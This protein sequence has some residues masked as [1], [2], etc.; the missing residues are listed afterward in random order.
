MVSALQKAIASLYVRNGYID[1]PTPR[2]DD[3]E[4]DMSLPEISTLMCNLTY[5]GYA[6]SSNALDRLKSLSVA[7]A[8]FWSDVIN[9]TL[10]NLTGA[11]R[12]MDKHVV[13]KNFPTEVLGMSEAEYWTKQILMY[14]G[15]PNNLFTEAPVERQVLSDKN[16]QY[17]V[18]QLSSDTTLRMIFFGLLNVPSRW[19][20]TQLSDV[21]LLAIKF[22]K[23]GT[24]ALEKVKFKENLVAIACFYIH[25]NIQ[26]RAS[27]LTDV[28]RLAAALSGSD[29]SL[30]TKVL[31]KK[32]DR[33]KRKFL[34]S[35]I[36][37]CLVKSG[38]AL[39]DIAKRKVLWKKL[40]KSI[41]PG[42]YAKSFPKTVEAYDCL[43]HNRF[44]NL[45]MAKIEHGLK[46]GDRA[47]LDV[48]KQR[49]GECVRRLRSAIGVFGQEAVDVFSQILSKLQMIQL[50][51]L[52]GHFK[53]L[54]SRNYRLFPPKGKWS[55]LQVVETSEDYNIPEES[56]RRVMRLISEEVRSR[57]MQ[58]IPVV[59]IDPRVAKI[60]IQTNDNEFAPYGRGTVFY[61][62]KTTQF[63]RSASYWK[64]STEGN[65]YFDNGWNFFDESWNRKGT[66]CWDHTH[67]IGAGAVF[68]GDPTNSKDIEGRACQMID[69]Y[70]RQLRK[71]GI[72]YAVWNILCYS[73]TEFSK[74]EEVYGTLQWGDDPLSGKLFEPQ[75]CQLNFQLKDECFTKYLALVDLHLTPMEC[76]YLDANLAASVQSA[77][78]NEEK[79]SEVMPGFME[80][81]DGLPSVAS[82]FC[83]IPNIASANSM[84]IASPTEQKEGEQQ[85]DECHLSTPGFKILYDDEGNDLDEGEQAYVFQQRNKNN[86]FSP[87]DLNELMEL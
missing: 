70:P 52:R 76:I 54:N 12:E 18:L 49:P 75:R 63:I 1:M 30:R 81:L 26:C 33:R 24:T 19:T 66:C 3:K 72:R 9:P 73:R 83:G 48:L 77:G 46:T 42:D 25:K 74:A 4:G 5:Y 6:L 16:I 60:K 68:S 53:V 69:L 87:F 84:P 40:L 36:E 64:E 28:L 71:C 51:K 78:Q 43:Y 85:C 82:L 80:Y 65:T 2:D 37:E 23:E 22:Q 79:L 61:I 56:R 29:H 27:T 50:L 35:M 59:D 44:D 38:S 58:K 62:P 7:E 67:D 20:D 21:K 31:F 55:K 41:H 47:V 10:A 32:F 39:D 13:Y 8:T 86:N 14:W 11:D 45:I 17:K 57:V 15:L 34:L